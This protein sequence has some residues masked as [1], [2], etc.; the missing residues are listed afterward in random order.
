MDA[1]VLNLL[2]LA[3]QT[4]V[5]SGSTELYGKVAS[6]IKE[7]VT[8]GKR[9]EVAARL[10]AAA[11][12]VQQAPDRADAE[13]ER[14]FV[15]LQS[16][17]D[18]D[19][20]KL[21]DFVSSAKALIR[22]AQPGIVAYSGSV[23]QQINFIRHVGGPAA[24]DVSQEML[25]EA[26]ALIRDTLESRKDLDKQ[27]VEASRLAQE[28]QKEAK[29]AQ[30]DVVRASAVVLELKRRIDELEHE[31][32]ALLAQ[33]EDANRQGGDIAELERKLA[34]AREDA[35]RSRE[36]QLQSQREL[37][38][39]RQQQAAAE[40][41]ADKAVNE[42]ER[43]QQSWN[44]DRDDDRDL[45]RYEQQLK[46]LA[47][48]RHATQERLREISESIGRPLR[49]LPPDPAAPLALPTEP[50]PPAESTAPAEPT[51][52]RRVLDDSPDAPG[53]V[54]APVSV[55]TQGTTAAGVASVAAQAGG[56]GAASAQPTGSGS[57]DKAAPDDTITGAGDG[58]WQGREASHDLA[59]FM[60]VAFGVVLLCA[61]VGAVVTWTTLGSRDG[62]IGLNTVPTAGTKPT[63]DVDDLRSLDYS[64]RPGATTATTFTAG[65]DARR[66]F[67][68][69]L[70][71][72]ALNSSCGSSATVTYA[73]YSDGQL[74]RHGDIPA[75][76]AN[77]SLVDLAVGRNTQL[78][79]VADM[80]GATA[81]RSTLELVQPTLDKLAG[82]E[83]GIANPN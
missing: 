29:A 74:I 34:S 28:S 24:P 22:E 12:H 58:S 31:R 25:T 16:L 17:V 9:D 4:I 54:D 61:I 67:N 77:A 30:D 53:A 65:G 75:D 64:M 83:R 20:Q 8:R 33:L 39:A 2:K 41:I 38:E 10:D 78:K 35:R 59:D 49:T 5:Q 3:L 62:W 46:N 63:N 11:E 48:E 18:L 80:Q 81:C 73:I 72:S 60:A 19:R 71:T 57:A 45:E 36:L 1:E 51:G 14:L 66:Y 76:G 68:T 15:D 23:E 6:K 55:G 82:W 70:R 43:R 69:G 21:E 26:F 56:R 52:A 13:A 79:F 47:D 42:L 37:R 7:M 50:A 32:A 27:L 44:A 40:R